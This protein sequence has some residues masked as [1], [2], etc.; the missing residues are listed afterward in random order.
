MTIALTILGCNGAE[1]PTETR[2]TPT[3]NSGDLQPPHFDF[4]A[5]GEDGKNYVGSAAQLSITF[6]V[7]DGAPVIRLVLGGRDANSGVSWGVAMVLSEE[8][9]LGTVPVSGR[10][11]RAPLRAG[12]VNLSTQVANMPALAEEGTLSLRLERG[13]ITGKAEVVPSALSATIEGRLNV[14]CLVPKDQLGEAT[15]G[16]GS[17]PG[18]STEY[19]SDESFSTPFCQKYAALR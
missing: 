7:G 2:G 13:R 5:Q 17:G 4:L 3:G 6:R 12:I 11:A 18:A 8:Q 16:H 19:A 1:P 10:I 14:S 15:N 9:A